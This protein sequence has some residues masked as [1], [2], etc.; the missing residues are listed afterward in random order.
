MPAETRRRPN[1][2]DPRRRQRPPDSRNATAYGGS[3][4]ADGARTAPSPFLGD[5][6]PNGREKAE[7]GDHLVGDVDWDL[8]DRAGDD[9]LARP[10]PFTDRVEEPGR[11]QDLRLVPT[12]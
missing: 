4:H 12:H 8:N 1:G 3:G 11:P 9:A 5:L 7:V 10:K 6:Q 2:H